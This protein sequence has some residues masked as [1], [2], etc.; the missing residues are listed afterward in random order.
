MPELS[1]HFIRPEVPTKST[2]LTGGARDAHRTSAQNDTTQT[3]LGERISALLCWVS[4]LVEPYSW[5][6]QKI[7]SSDPD[8]GL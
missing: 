5:A 6:L 7:C 8:V 1:R 4:R 3:K 2:D